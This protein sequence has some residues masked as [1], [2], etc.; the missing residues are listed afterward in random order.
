MV[1]TL[2]IYQP[3]QWTTKTTH[4]VDSS[5]LCNDNL[6]DE[7]MPQMTLMSNPNPAYRMTKHMSST[8]PGETIDEHKST[9]RYNTTSTECH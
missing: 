5:Y 6:D 3:L 7:P 9:A 8:N 1:T 2:T 4:I